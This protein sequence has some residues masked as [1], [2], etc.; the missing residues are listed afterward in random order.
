MKPYISANGFAKIVKRDTKTVIA[1]I[2]SGFIPG[3]RRIGHRYAI[4]V[5]EIEVFQTSADYPPRKWQ[6]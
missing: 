3:V 2:H 4:P 5:K 1:W 6:K